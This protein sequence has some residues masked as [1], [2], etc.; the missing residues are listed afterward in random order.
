MNSNN[1]KTTMISRR[2]PGFLLGRPRTQWKGVMARRVEENG[3]PVRVITLADV[4]GPAY[5][6]LRLAA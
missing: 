6:E 3:P 1:K 4:H 2:V 5:D